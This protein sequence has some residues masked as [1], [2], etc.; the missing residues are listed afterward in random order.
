MWILF[1]L[2][3]IQPAV[4]SDLSGLYFHV[5]SYTRDGALSTDAFVSIVLRDPFGR[6]T[7]YNPFTGESLANIPYSGSDIDSIDDYETGQLGPK[8]IELDVI[9]A[10]N[11]GE[12]LLSVIGGITGRY[13]ITLRAKNSVGDRIANVEWFGYSLVGSTDTFN[14]VFNPTPGA[15]A[16]FMLKAVTFDVLRNDVSVARQL[17]QLGDDKF[18]RSLAKNIDLTEKLS[19]KCDKHRKDKKCA[20]SIAVLKLFIKRLELANR[21]CDNPADCDEERE[22]AAFRN[23]HGGDNDYKDFFRDWDKDGWHKDKKTAKRFVTD[24]ALKI[25]SDDVQWLIKSLGGE[26]SGGKR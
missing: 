6:E 1:I 23:V 25:I 4:A 14:F 18:V 16:P 8:S 22:W 26:V 19:G 9:P 21:K 7:S 11:S 17:N 24:E 5:N 12:Y 2:L 3:F 10:A 15:P 20:P 13:S